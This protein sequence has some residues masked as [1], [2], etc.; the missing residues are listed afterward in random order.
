MAVSKEY[1]EFIQE[2]LSELDDITYRQMMGEYIVYYKG[3]ITAYLCDNRFLVKPVPAAAAMLPEAA[4]EPPY[5]GAKNMI[6]V[7]RVDDKKLL[8][9]LFC[10]MYNELPE[11]KKKRR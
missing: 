2:Q 5:E 7:D 11:P 1:L 9:E 10:A 3:K 4:Y 8:A 6:L